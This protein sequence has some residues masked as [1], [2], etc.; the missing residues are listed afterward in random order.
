M[1]CYGLPSHRRYAMS[2]ALCGP[3][4]EIWLKLSLDT[5]WLSPQICQ[6]YRQTFLATAEFVRFCKSMCCLSHQ[7][8]KGHMSRTS[9]V[10][11]EVRTPLKM[12]GTMLK[13]ETIVVC[14]SF[15][16]VFCC[17]AVYC[18]SRFRAELMASNKIAPFLRPVM[19]KE[20]WHT[21]KRIVS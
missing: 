20:H 5:S 11:A 3:I 14:K 18:Q 2:L 9:S 10:R 6:L 15:I 1:P 7:A 13:S 17:F 16:C 19:P 12:K 21:A 8:Q 4:D